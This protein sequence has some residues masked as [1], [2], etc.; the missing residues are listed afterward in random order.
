MKK[1][2]RYQVTM[3]EKQLRL[4]ERVLEDWTRLFCGQIDHIFNSISSPLWNKF[5]DKYIDTKEWEDKCALL[6]SNIN[7]IKKLMFNLQSNESYG[8]GNKFIPNTNLAYEV[9]KVINNFFY[10]RIPQEN[11]K[12]YSVLG[13]KP[14]KYTKEPFI[15]IEE[16][17][18]KKIK[19]N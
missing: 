5:C 19:N 7:C 4:I 8:V 16:I 10:F 9:Y 6:K 1:A 15:Q 17:R 13:N 11:R 2:K 3:T 14:L 12:D 18:D